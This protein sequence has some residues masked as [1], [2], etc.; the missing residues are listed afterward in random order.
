MSVNRNAPYKNNVYILC[1]GTEIVCRV[2][3][4]FRTVLQTELT[5]VQPSF[6]PRA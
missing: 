5:V 3:F 2:I 6:V 4:T 1:H